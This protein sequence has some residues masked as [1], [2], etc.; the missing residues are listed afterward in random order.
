VHWS[1]NFDEIQD[2]EH[3]IR[4]AF[5]GLGF[6]DDPG[7]G[8][9]AIGTPMGAPKAGAS[10]ELDALAAFVTSL[11]TVPRSPFRNADGSLTDDGAAGERIFVALGCDACHAGPDFTD[12]ATGIVH[13]VGTITA[14]SGQRLG[15]ALE[16]ID[17]PTLLGVWQTAPYLHDGSA[18]TLEDVL[19]ARNPDDRHGATSTLSPAEL[20]QLVA[21]LKQIDGH[22]PP[23][24]LPFEDEATSAPGCGCASD[25]GHASTWLLLGLVACRRRRAAHA[26]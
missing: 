13:D 25:R 22:G 15:G 18:A 5:G 26:R 21:Y 24:S 7:F 1:A 2:F 6:I 8:E 11:D 16:G 10:A 19:V 17:T 9:S 20:D 3:D 23:T 14:L 4:N 12:S